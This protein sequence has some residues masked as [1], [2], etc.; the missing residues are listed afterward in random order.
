MWA[1]FNAHDVSA[2]GA[3][4]TA[5]AT[6]VS[7]GPEGLK[8]R[9]KDEFLK[10]HQG[11]FAGVPDVK[12]SPTRVFQINDVTV[13]EW[14]GTGTDTGG[15]MGEKPTNKKVGFHGVTVDWFND[16]GLAKR[17][18]NYLDEGTIAQQM[19]KVPGK[20]RPVEAAP[21]GDPQWIAA[22]GNDAEAKLVDWTKT[23]SW[24][25]T[26]SKHDKKAYEA[27][28]ADDSA[29][30]DYGMPNDYVGKKAL[31]GEYDAWAKAMPDLTFTVD[32]IWAAG[33]TVLFQWTGTGTM[34]GNMGPLKGNGKALTV[35]GFEVDGSKDGKIT[36]GYTY[37]NSLEVLG[38]L[39]MLPKPKEPKGEKKK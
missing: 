14:I 17:E 31:M 25:A 36:K 19:G 8:E 5:D 37:S 12:V 18:A 22:Q 39:G 30:Y 21:T 11:L 4:Y 33:D 38:Q 20:A 10:M 24:P 28:V 34:K 2:M 13:T 15:M 16:D 3:S 29:H 7:A 27:T 26:W 9:S 6:F 1:A 35:H 32:A 23:A